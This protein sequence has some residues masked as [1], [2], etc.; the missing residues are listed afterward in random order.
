MNTF[1]Q[2]RRSL[3]LSMNGIAAQA[4]KNAYPEYHLVYGVDLVRIK[5][6]AALYPH[7]T[8]LALSLWDTSCR[9]EMLVATSL[10]DITDKS[11]NANKLVNH[12]TETAFT[13]EIRLQL[14]RNYL[15]HV[16]SSS[17]LNEWAISGNENQKLCALITATLLPVLALDTQT[18]NT[19]LDLVN[20]F[21]SDKKISTCRVLSNFFETLLRID[22]AKWKPKIQQLS[23]TNPSNPLLLQEIKTKIN[24][25]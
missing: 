13:D 8:S 2:I 16:T 12:L 9:E 10:F 4:L 25:L 3:R 1:E 20:L 5:E 22:T 7:D 11:D 6:I 19:L 21:S 18:L 15:K 14:A 23:T 17:N 24:K